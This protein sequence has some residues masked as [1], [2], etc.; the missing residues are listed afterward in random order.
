MKTKYGYGYVRVSTDKQE[1]LSPDSQAKLLKDFAHKNGIIISKIFYEL[2]VSGRKA[3][4]RPEFQKMIA[5]A[6]SSD[7]PVDA[8]LVWKF[9]RFARNQEESIVYKSL[10]KK[11]HNVDVISVS[12]P[13]VDGP[14][15]SLI[16]RIIEWM[17]EYYSVR[18]SGEVTRGMTEKAKRGGYQARP[19]LGYRIAERGKPPVI[20]DEE[21]EIIRIIFQKY[22]LEGMGM[23]DIARYLNLCGFKT[24]H[25]KEFERRSVEYILENPTYCGMIRWNRTVNET[26]EIRP[27]DEWIIADGQ[28][29][30]IISKE[31]FDRAAA[32][33]NME[34][35]PRGSRPSSTYRHWL[36]GLVKC[37]VCGRTMIAK[38]IVNGKRTYCYFVCYGY[39]KGKCLAKNSISSLK[40]APAVLQSLKD[41]L[42]NQQLSFRYIQPE[43][44]TA[45]DLSD[46]LLDQLK[47]IDEKLD[48]IKEAYRNG[49][50]TLEE[51]KENKALVQNE[52]QLL[53]KQLAELPAQDSE[54]DQ[55]ES[56]LLDRVKNVY[57][58]VN[59]ESVDDV[60][61][62]EILK[63]IIEKIVYNK[64]KDTL[65][66]YYYY[67][68]QTQ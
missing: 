45:P 11:K 30:A 66:V 2:G 57:E 42:N 58:I 24:S 37:P 4:K 18:L 21:A 7:H 10:L 26:N 62:N 39:S 13:L 19:P 47:R 9:S 14:F 6:K 23:F 46:I 15:G 36:S 52:K 38:K 40:L 43:P 34:Y 17:D 68:P 33:R 63:S 35:K 56:A 32:R 27:K 54:S 64:E 22:A 3:E 65:E 55:A 1:E 31:L 67:K 53:E 48:R 61:K 20:V 49:V 51:Y 29:P 28:Q 5:M 60:I 44:E 25:G 8:I 59:S 41:V 50:D 16:E 12:E